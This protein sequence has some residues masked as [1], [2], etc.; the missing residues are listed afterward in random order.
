MSKVF[1]RA[2]EFRQSI[3]ES[4]SKTFERGYLTG[5]HTLDEYMSFKLGYTTYIYSFP[6][7]GKSVFISDI[8]ISLA[9]RH[10][11][12]IAIYSPEFGKKESL[13]HSLVQAYMAKKLYGEN[14]QEST[15][16]EWFRAIDFVDSHFVILDPPKK[17]KRKKLSEGGKLDFNRFSMD[18]AF[19]KVH[20]AET[21]YGWD[22][23]MFVID[24]FNYVDKSEEDDRK[25]TADYIL[26]QLQYINELSEAMELH[27]ILINHLRDADRIVDKDTGIEYYPKPFPSELLGG[28]Q[29]WRVGYQMVGLFRC[30]VGVIEKGKGVAYPAN[31]TDVLVQK[32]KPYG[33]G[34]LGDCR[35]FFDDDRQCFYE[36]INGNKYYAGDY[37]Q[38]VNGV[39]PKE[40]KPLTPNYNFDEDSNPF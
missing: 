9:K 30:P 34:K 18:V 28:Q 4:K 15:D 3:V 17:A 25:Q 6:H 10:D 40:L 12:K 7:V 19:R 2:N 33:A 5:F 27:T 36:F 11:L 32:S 24:P 21:A 31:A 37:Y 29:F 8:L 1:F 38:E 14:R 39:T 16:D 13:V 26:D 22:I 35:L 20:E 23:K